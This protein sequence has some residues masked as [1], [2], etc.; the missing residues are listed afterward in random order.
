[1]A[2]P[3][4][5]VPTSFPISVPVITR[6]EEKNL[7]R[8]LASLRGIASEIIVVDCG[9]TDKTREIAEKYQA[10]WI[11]Q[12]WLGY[13]DQKNF[14]LELCRQEWVLALDADEE[15]SLELHQEILLF[16]QN[17]KD[18]AGASFPRKVWFMDQ[19]IKHGD[20]YPDR[21]LRLVKRQNA[22]WGG[23][24]EHDKMELPEGS[25]ILKMKGDLHHFSFPSIHRYIDKINVFSNVYLE[26]QLSA[27]KRFSLLDALFRP[28]WRFFRAYIIRLGFLDG[29]PGFWIAMGTS[30]ATFIRHSKLYE[31]EHTKEPPSAKT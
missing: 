2:T 10:R 6:N 30:Y 13:R 20:W 15:I 23:S 25:K 22:R 27:G 28:W 26:R 17:P 24:R 19:W 18:Y 12:D 14:A 3:P 29:F 4:V 31:K 21:K 9:S 11:H 1:M 8:C 7:D 5:S 16:F